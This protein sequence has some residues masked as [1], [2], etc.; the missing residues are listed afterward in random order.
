MQTEKEKILHVFKQMF[1]LLSKILPE[2]RPF[3]HKYLQQVWKRIY[4]I[5][6]SLHSRHVPYSLEGRF[7]SYVKSEESRL[8]AN[9]A[10]IRYDIDE[11]DT[12]KLV[13]GPGRI[14]KVL[15]KFLESMVVCIR[16]MLV[17]IFGSISFLWSV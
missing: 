8:K 2:N 6:S 7:T 12:L 10:E 14:E 9:L 5:I 17:L 4:E 13:T 16:L 1:G 3:A 15:S 11:M